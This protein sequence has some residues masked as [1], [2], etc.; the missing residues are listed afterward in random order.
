MPESDSSQGADAPLSP[1]RSVQ[2]A[3]QK[4]LAA[5]QEI[6]PGPILAKQHLMYY[7]LL[8]VLFTMAV[9]LTLTCMINIECVAVCVLMSLAACVWPSWTPK[10]GICTGSNTV[11]IRKKKNKTCSEST[12]FLWE[13]RLCTLCPSHPLSGVLGS[14]ELVSWVSL[15]DDDVLSVQ[16]GWFSQ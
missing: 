14:P 3:K 12:A 11:L 8:K 2:L 4:S 6:D 1:A 16:K 10:P 7:R 13:K 9:L 15:Q 5:V